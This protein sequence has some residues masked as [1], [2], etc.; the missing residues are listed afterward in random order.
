MRV[1]ALAM[2]LAA[3]G[4]SL[5]RADAVDDYLVKEQA[6]RQ[7]PGMAMAIV[8]H[9]RIERTSTYGSANLETGT[10][11]TPDSVFA[12]ASLDKAITTTGVMKAAELGQLTLDDPIGKYV[13]VP[14]PGVTLAM[15]LSH[16][17][18]L[19]DM[20][21]VLASSYGAHTFQ[22]YSTPELLAAI[23]EAALLGP[24][25]GQY[26]YSDAGLFLAQLA[27]QAA[28][29]KPWFAF[30]QE[31]IFRPAGMMNVVE[32][33]P[34]AIIPRRVSG[35]TFDAAD[36]L[37]RDD[38]TDV[39]YGEL[40]NDLG[41]PIGDFARWLIL[42]D[43]HGPLSA[44]SV[45]RMWTQTMLY[46]GA[47]AREVYSFSG[48]GLGTGLDDVLGQRAI[49]HTGHSGV[50]WVKFPAL[51]LAVVVFTNL[52]HPRGSDPAGLALGVAGLLEPEVSLRALS[53]L[54]SEPQ[55]ARGLRKD[56]EAFLDGKPDL[57]RYTPHM[58]PA[59][60]VN[61]QTFAGRL[62]R[63]GPLVSWQYLKA[64]PVEGEPTYLFRA[65]HAHG[66][67]YLRYSLDPAGH[68]SRLVWWHL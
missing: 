11:V 21:A 37:V 27:T 8:R 26:S 10:P 34:H 6:S 4:A 22:H 39:E 33:D 59:M 32:L 41:M 20:D 9:G 56:Y 25:G 24:P 42:L 65:T 62:P 60:W 15:L 29:G 55:A 54:K 46:D 13:D 17:S 57:R 45:Q 68:I 1:L 36:H 18:G 5:L 44:R 43:G 35:Y 53:P 3:S 61:R 58:Q 23:R 64:A 66:E 51:D 47:P 63:L 2:G 50:A 16:T 19:P 48:Y 31:A 28:T 12:I 7:I 49:L 67:I 40:Y 14:L 30:M 52:E 38:R